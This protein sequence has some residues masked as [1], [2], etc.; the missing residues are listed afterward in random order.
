MNTLGNQF[1]P[2]TSFPIDHHRCIDFRRFLGQG[3]TFQKFLVLSVQI[4]ETVFLDLM[5]FTLLGLVHFSTQFQNGARHLLNVCN[6]LR[7]FD[8]TNQAALI[9]HR[10]RGIDG[11]D[12]TAVLIQVGLFL[13]QGGLAFFQCLH[14]GT[15]FHVLEDFRKGL[16]QNVMAFHL[17]QHGHGTVI[18]HAVSFRIHHVNTFIDHLKDLFHYDEIVSVFHEFPPA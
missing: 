1:L 8:G 10:N 16:F 5:L 13:S 6:V 17:F 2:G 18:D 12:F 3:D 9:H 7:D 4:I 14:Q 15:F 11:C